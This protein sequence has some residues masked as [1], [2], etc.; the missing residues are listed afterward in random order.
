MD[1][2]DVHELGERFDVALCF[3]ILHRVTGPIEHSKAVAVVT[4]DPRRVHQP[5]CSVADLDRQYPQ[6]S[7]PGH[8]A[9]IGRQRLGRALRPR[10]HLTPTRPLPSEANR[11]ATV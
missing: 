9:R 10:H 1:A 5:A 11:V 6:R 8:D 4:R 7:G 2:F 3:R